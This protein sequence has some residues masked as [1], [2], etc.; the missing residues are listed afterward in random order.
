MEKF[1]LV[2]GLGASPDNQLIPCDNVF[3]VKPLGSGTHN[4]VKID[5]FESDSS[6][7]EIEVFHDDGTAAENITMCN[8]IADLILKAKQQKYGKPYLEI[9]A[10]DFPSTVTNVGLS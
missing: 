6:G 10:A 4:S 7:H 2:T 1:I 8:F 9:D 5:Y 3:V